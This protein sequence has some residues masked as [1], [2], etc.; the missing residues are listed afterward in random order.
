MKNATTVRHLEIHDLNITLRE[1]FG[2]SG[3]TQDAVRNLLVVAEL[4]DGTRGYGEA[5]PLPAFNGE[6]QEIARAAIESVRARIE[7]CDV[8]E[9]R[10]VAAV[11]RGAIPKVGSARCA[12]ETALLDALTR[13][14]GM[15]LWAF[16][17]GREAELVT[18]MTIP[19]GTV[20]RAGEATRT[21]AARGFRTFKVKIGGVALGEDIDRIVAVHEAAP[22]ATLVADANAGLDAAVALELL[23]ALERRGVRLALLEQPVAGT[24]LEGLARVTAAG[25]AP[26]AADESCA[27]VEG[28]WTIASRGAAN[29]LN[30]KL[31][32]FGVA[33]ALDIAAVARAAGLGLMIGGMVESKL[34]MSMSACFAAGVG[35]FTHIDLDTPLFMAEEPLD[36]GLEYDGATVKLRHI[37]AGHGVIPRR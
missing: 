35:G 28:A 5:A 22:N 20:A 11:L 34:T 32:K 15:P 8:R 1:P 2:I 21:W 36:G 18:D 14:A 24:D 26:V 29:V 23:D 16:F 27:S 9:W 17:G 37:A 30:L 31:S 7:G 33:E 4:A 12:I 19:T 10:A 13:R 6:T 3:G 25:K